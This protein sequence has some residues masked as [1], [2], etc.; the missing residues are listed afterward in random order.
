[1][2]RVKPL[3]MSGVLVLSLLACSDPQ[4]RVQRPLDV[5]VVTAPDAARPPDVVRH[6]APTCPLAALVVEPD[7]DAPTDGL[8]GMARR[9]TPLTKG[10]TCEVADS[11]LARVEQA[12]L[13]GPSREVP[14]TSTPWDH[15]RPPKHLGLVDTRFALQPDERALLDRNG[16]VVLARFADDWASLFH[17]VFQSQLP[18]YVSV[19]AVMHAIYLGNDG[20][21]ADLEDAK[22]A[23]M[24][25]RV[26]DALACALPAAAGDYPAETARDLD[27]Y[28]TVARALL[29]GEPP[30]SMFG[31]PTV[32]AEATKLVAAADA[33]AEMT[34]VSMFGRERVIDFTAYTPRSHYAKTDARKRFFRAGM[35]LSRLELNLV[36]RDSRSSQPGEVPDP[37]ETPREDIL[38]LA[39]ADLV[40]RSGAADD[41]ARLDGAW[42]L[43][44]GR[45]EDVSV[46]Q[47]LELRAQAGIDKLTDPTAAQRLRTAI[48]TRFQRTARLH[49][50]PEG[51]RTL[52]AI[53]TLL[54]PRVVPDAQATR[55]IVADEVA[56]R[57]VLHAADMAYALGHD[58]ALAYL[59]DD[60]ARFPTLEH[61]LGAARTIMQTTPRG[62]DDLY[63]AW[64]DAII[65]IAR[66]DVGARPSFASTPAYADLRMN[67]ALV[68]FGHLKHNFV[69]AV[70]E[71]Y[72]AG[73]CEIPDGYVEPATA[74]Y[75][76]LLDYLGRL[77]RALPQLDPKDET[78]GLA[79]VKNLRRVLET[80]L[81]IQ[82]D[83]LLGKPLSKAQRE[84]LS[85]VVEMAPGT[86]GGP[87][88][89]TGWWFDMF[90][91]R[92]LDGRADADYIASFFTGDKIAYVGAT[93][94]RLGVFVVDT[95]G[96]P[97]LAVGPVARGYEIQG[98]QAKRL[99]DD[100]AKQLAD[101]DRFAPWATSYTAAAPTVAAP[102]FS[103]S[104]APGDAIQLEAKAAIGPV[105]I[106]ILDH[107]RKPI[108]KATRTIGAGKTTWKIKHAKDVAEGLHLIVGKWH[109]W[110]EV[111]VVEGQVYSTFGPAEETEGGS[112]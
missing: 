40:K 26:L 72:F 41:V 61:Q 35:W 17:E 82:R 37:T 59:A 69:L 44:A 28:V 53:T 52:P 16:F 66:P 80:L 8:Q 9:E 75:A 89:Y 18:I 81:A 96:A 100:D 2:K 62:K 20:L 88:T 64:L 83:E 73:G 47:L 106:E 42:A 51:S 94:P 39:L 105:T 46:A 77:E 30:A 110:E 90:R 108:A 95:G 36:S 49:Y 31:D 60:R 78:G 56:G 79:Y 29:R 5:A 32:E 6:P 65:A 99:S 54:G 93:A 24:V 97:R 34:K 23:P 3:G 102:A 19:D 67:S 112:N 70:G 71:S 107:H 48:G 104:W 13:T 14:V 63:S 43:L 27:L 15:K 58:R 85:M 101:A 4:K 91:H 74:A 12:I 33:A 45:R 7:P 84:F 11:N 109:A 55:P 98:P 10:G 68:A 92:E 76:G 25:S 38:A 50:M 1:M 87:P 22:L 103:I 111:G 21:I 86:T 57:E